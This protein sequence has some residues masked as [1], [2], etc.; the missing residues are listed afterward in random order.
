MFMTTVKGDKPSVG[1][2]M[3]TASHLPFNRNGLKF[4]T[5]QGG[6][7]KKDISG[8]LRI[9]ED[10]DYTA[11]GSESSVKK[12]NFIDDYTGFLVNYIRKS[13]DIETNFE[14]PLHGLKIIVDAGNG[15]GGFF[16]FKVLDQLGAR[17]YRESVS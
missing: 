5:S 12:W 10:K 17:H 8:I 7:N 11:S 9:A 4:F 15:A 3:I 2:V 1:G 16:A 13:A 6:L 14:K